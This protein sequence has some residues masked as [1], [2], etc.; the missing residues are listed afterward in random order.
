MLF[1]RKKSHEDLSSRRQHERVASRN[2]V[3][4]LR[5]D[6]AELERLTNVYDLSE[7]GLRLVCHEALAPGVLLRIILNIPENGTTLEL[8][9]RTAWSCPMKGQKGAYFA[10]VQFLDLSEKNREILRGAVE[11][12]KPGGEAV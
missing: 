7:G 10:G 2:L 8:K 5:D 4:V 1:G 9:A 12:R 3:R 11:R 6:G